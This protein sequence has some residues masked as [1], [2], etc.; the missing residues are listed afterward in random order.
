MPFTIE[1]QPSP[2]VTLLVVMDRPGQY[3]P[4]VILLLV[5]L[6]SWAVYNLS[7]R[8]G[9]ETVHEVIAFISG[10]VLFVSV[11]FGVFV[12]YPLL[13]LRGASLPARVIGAFI[14]PLGWMIKESALLF[15][16]YSAAECLYYMLNPLNVAISLV[17][18]AQM[19]LCEAVMRTVSGGEARKTSA[20]SQRFATYVQKI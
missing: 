12:I 6:I 3:R 4:P 7:W 20:Q 14:T 11:G 17:I 16:S 8:I 1:P 18:A 15:I 10:S 5:M 19:G 2:A 9:V 13:Y